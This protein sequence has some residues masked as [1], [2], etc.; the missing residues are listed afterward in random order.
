MNKKERLKFIMELLDRTHRIHV[1][2]LA[3]ELGTSDDTIRR[4]IE[5]LDS[6]GILKKVHGG[7]ISK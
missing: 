2:D 4:D 1:I 5:Q 6:K 7:A 3:K